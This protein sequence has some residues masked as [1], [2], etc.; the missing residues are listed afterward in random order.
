MQAFKLVLRGLSD[1]FHSNNLVS[2]SV[3][4]CGYVGPFVS[5]AFLDSA[6]SNSAISR[7]QAC[8]RD[9]PG[10]VTGGDGLRRGP[11]RSNG[12]NM[13]VSLESMRARGTWK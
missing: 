1:H 4:V 13:Y 10:F 2:Y 9:T 12:H 11:E 6:R 7:R 8:P 5:L 3:G